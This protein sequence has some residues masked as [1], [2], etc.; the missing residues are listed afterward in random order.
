MPDLTE[1]RNV[2]K[3]LGWDVTQPIEA[4]KTKSFSKK[5]RELKK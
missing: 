5:D 2:S 1:Q 4:I 3:L